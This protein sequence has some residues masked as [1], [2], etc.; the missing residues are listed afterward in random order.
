MKAWQIAVAS[1]ALLAPAGCRT[2]PGITILERQNFCLERENERLRGMI[3]DMQNEARDNRQRLA[4]KAPADGANFAP[5]YKSGAAGR[6]EAAENGP[7]IEAPQVELPSQSTNKEPESLKQP[8][9]AKPLEGPPPPPPSR[10]TDAPGAAPD[11]PAIYHGDQSSL[12]PP[13]AS[14]V[15]QASLS[16]PVHPSGDSLQVASLAIDRELSGGV[17]AAGG[18]GDDGLLLAVALRDCRGRTVAAPADMSVAVFDPALCDE[19][20]MA[21][22]VGRWD[23]TAA[24]TGALFRRTGPHRAVH[25]TMAW[26][27]GPPKHHKLHVFVRYRT[28]DGRKLL[29]DGPIDMGPLKRPPTTR[30]LAPVATQGPAARDDGPQLLPVDATAPARPVWSPDR[31]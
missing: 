5:Q 17:A 11:G 27:D 16:V 30:A 15:R 9:G 12:R 19:E 29:T 3:E 23:F 20:G 13:V 4:P 21:V 22:L 18:P 1:A 2:D 31:Q 7:S 6:S 8:A 28:A 14:D 10:G 25:L 24:E 26:P